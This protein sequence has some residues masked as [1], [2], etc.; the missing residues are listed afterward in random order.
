MWTAIAPTWFLF[1]KAMAGVDWI[2]LILFPL[3]QIGLE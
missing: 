2:G 3:M 1:W